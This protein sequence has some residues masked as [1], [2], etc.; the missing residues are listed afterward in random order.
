M[1]HLSEQIE[2]NKPING[3][4]TSTLDRRADIGKILAISNG[5]QGGHS[6]ATYSA[7]EYYDFYAG[8]AYSGGDVVVNGSDIEISKGVFFLRCLPTFGTSVSSTGPNEAR[9]QFVDENDNP[10]GNKASINFNNFA[11]YPAPPV[12]VGIAQGPGIF[13]LKF[14]AINAGTFN[15]SGASSQDTVNSPYLLDIIRL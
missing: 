13:R 14:D 11:T 1:S 2:S 4:I 9:M 3:N 7:G 10:V 5:Q 8:A 6:S 15:G 12:C